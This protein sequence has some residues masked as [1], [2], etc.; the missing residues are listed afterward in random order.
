[1]NTS[2]KNKPKSATSGS[3]EPTAQEYNSRDDAIPHSNLAP[4]P[5]KMVPKPSVS[6]CSGEI[7]N[8]YHYIQS[9]ATSAIPPTRTIPTSHPPQE[10]ASYRVEYQQQVLPP[11]Q[12]QLRGVEQ[13]PQQQPYYEETRAAPL[14]VITDN[15]MRLLS[16]KTN[17][18][19]PND[20][21][22]QVGMGD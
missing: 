21:F 15:V 3:L 5:V 14:R 13:Q 19:P 2:I 9:S 17:R 18:Q 10:L 4:Y 22:E 6:E 7:S 12:C 20:H 16:P 8:L 1:M 11:C